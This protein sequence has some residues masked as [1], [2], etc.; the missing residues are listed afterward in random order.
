MK[1]FVA[2]IQF[3]TL[4][5]NAI[6]SPRQ[7]ARFVK[8]YHLDLG[9]LQKEIYGRKHRKSY[10]ISFNVL[11]VSRATLLTTRVIKGHV[12]Q[13]KPLLNTFLNGSG[14]Y[15]QLIS[16]HLS[17][18]PGR[19]VKKLYFWLF[20]TFLGYLCSLFSGW[21]NHTVRGRKSPPPQH[22]DHGQHLNIQQQYM[23]L[24]SQSSSINMNM[25][26]NYFRNFTY[27]Y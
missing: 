8:V 21:P 10:N 1:V 25:Y 22:L 13:L 17:L 19:K 2:L 6:T 23:W 9:I 12:E 14:G 3:K 24:Y 4:I 7:A 11:N 26:N 27:R 20:M 16:E 18:T 5:T 15:H